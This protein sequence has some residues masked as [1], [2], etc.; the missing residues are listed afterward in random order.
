[1]AVFH[2]GIALDPRSA[3]AD[4]AVIEESGRLAAKARWVNKMPNPAEVRR[5]AADLAKSPASAR[6]AIDALPQSPLT[7]ACS[8]FEDAAFYAR[9]GQGLP[10]VISFEAPL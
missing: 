4:R 1:M 9:R 10:V 2:R 7:Y 8:R 5:M 3:D 6:D